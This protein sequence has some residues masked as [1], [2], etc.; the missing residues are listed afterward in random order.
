LDSEAALRKTNLRF[1]G[2]FQ[3]MMALC[4]AQ[5]LS[6]ENLEDLQKEQLWQTAKRELAKKT[7]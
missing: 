6:W 5:G 1:E 4:K 7:E 2:R 3:K